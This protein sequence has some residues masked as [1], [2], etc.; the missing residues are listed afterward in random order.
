M[1]SSGVSTFLGVVART[2]RIASIGW[3]GMGRRVVSGRLPV[4]RH[5]FGG[6]AGQFAP[7]F[8]RI[9]AGPSLFSNEVLLFPQSG[10]APSSKSDR[11]SSP[12]SAP[13]AQRPTHPAV[14][15]LAR[16]ARAAAAGIYPVVGA[17][18]GQRGQHWPRSETAF[19]SNTTATIRRRISAFG[20]VRSPTTRSSAIARNSRRS[21]SG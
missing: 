14:P 1:N 7:F 19:G 17:Q 16:S 2:L 10:L 12:R 11:G 8:C 9:P 21:R 6:P 3:Y 20:P 5:R 4:L 18:F 13:P 15:A